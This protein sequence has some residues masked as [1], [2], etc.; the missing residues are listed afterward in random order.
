M[1]V[2][3]LVDS[4]SDISVEEENKLGINVLPLLVTINDK[5]YLDGVDLSKDEF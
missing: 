1:S 4:A 2:K 5:D 3:I